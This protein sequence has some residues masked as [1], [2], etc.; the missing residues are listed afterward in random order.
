MPANKQL[1]LTSL[2]IAGELL[3]RFCKL[4]GCIVVNY[5]ENDYIKVI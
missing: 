4:A 2:R 3:V 1:H 5:K